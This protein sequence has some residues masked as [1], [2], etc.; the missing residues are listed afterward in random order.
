MSTVSVVSLFVSRLSYWIFLLAL[1]FFLLC[2]FLSKFVSSAD[3]Y[4]FADETNYRHLEQLPG[5]SIPFLAQGTDM[6][7]YATNSLLLLLSMNL[8]LVMMLCF[9]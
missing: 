3:N 9:V 6:E 4:V 7:P 5:P 8:L 1:A 2:R